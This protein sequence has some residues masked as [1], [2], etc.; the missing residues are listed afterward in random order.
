MIIIGLNT[1]AVQDFKVRVAILMIGMFI[2]IAFSDWL[3][4]AVEISEQEKKKAQEELDEKRR[5]S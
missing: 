3:D 4:K 1:Q 5:Q 2:G